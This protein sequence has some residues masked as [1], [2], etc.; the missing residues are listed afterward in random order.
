[1]IYTVTG[2]IGIFQ[3][4]VGGCPGVVHVHSV[5]L[6]SAKDEGFIRKLP[7]V[8]CV[9]LRQCDPRRND[10]WHRVVWGSFSGLPGCDL[11]RAEVALAAY[12]AVDSWNWRALHANH[13]DDAGNADRARNDNAAFDRRFAERISPAFE[14]A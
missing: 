11:G 13:T 2:S 7:C 6:I 3:V 9:V 12:D 4:F 8:G 5:F 14:I 1:M 10:I